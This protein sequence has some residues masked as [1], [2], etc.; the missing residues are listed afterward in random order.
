MGSVSWQ[1][2]AASSAAELNAGLA[3]TGYGFELL[4][5]GRN[6]V[7][8]GGEKSGS[9]AAALQT[10]ESAWR[11]EGKIRPDYCAFRFGLAL[12]F[13]EKK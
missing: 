6:R 11:A 3:V 12:G 8:L 7:V 9:G 1:E 5:F 4:S 2:N 10:G 13:G